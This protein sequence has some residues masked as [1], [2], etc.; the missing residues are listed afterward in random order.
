MDSLPQKNLNLLILNYHNT[1]RIEDG[2]GGNPGEITFDGRILDRNNGKVCNTPEYPKEL[3]PDGVYC[4]F[5]TIDE[6]GEPAFP[7]II[8]ENFN[9]RPISKVVNVVSQVSISPLPRQTVYSS[10]IVDGTNLTV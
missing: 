10:Q 3:Y 8:G 1:S 4:Y 6:D 7:Y 2:T 5:V 9:N